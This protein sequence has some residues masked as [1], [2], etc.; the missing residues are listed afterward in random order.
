MKE[1]HWGRRDLAGDE[2][3]EVAMHVNSAMDIVR[4][5]STKSSKLQALFMEAITALDEIYE[6]E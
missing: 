4:N 6:A 5:K 3:D 1:K 2:L